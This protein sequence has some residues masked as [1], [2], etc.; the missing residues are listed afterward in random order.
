MALLVGPLAQRFSM[1]TLAR[2]GFLL[3]MLGLL[4]LALN[5]NS[6]LGLGLASLVFVTG[7]A[8]AVPTMI[9]LFG[10][11]AAPNRATGMAI[12]G[13]VLFLGAS[14]GPLLATVDLRFSTLLVL[15]AATQGFAALCLTVSK[16][17][18]L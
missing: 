2:A 9:T 3:A 10:E 14:I 13:V 18:S 8:F 11:A 15:L 17:F 7:V 1:H 5:T 12:N 16:R 4:L 6:T